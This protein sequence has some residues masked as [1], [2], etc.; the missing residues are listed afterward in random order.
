MSRLTERAVWR[1]LHD[2]AQALRSVRMLDL[3]AADPRR[4]E[5]FSVEASGLYLD[6][7]KQRADRRAVALLLQLAVEQSVEAWRARMF[8]GE[9]INATERRAALHVA[10]RAPCESSMQV[11]GVDVVPQVHAVL[12]RMSAFAERVRDGRWTGFN[13]G[14]ITDVVNL[15]IGGSDLGPRM[16][17]EALGSF[18]DG[19]RT[20]FIAN[21]DAAPLELLLRQ[22]DPATTLWIVASKSFTTLETLSNARLARAWFLQSASEVDVARHFVAVST[23]RAEVERFGIDPANMFEFWDWVGGRYSLWSAVGLPIIL[24][25]G[26]QR[27]RELL[28]GAWSMDRHF[29]QAPLAQNMPVLMAL[30]SIWNSNFVGRG[31]QVLAAY[32]QSLASFVNWAQQLDLESNGKSA[33]RDGERVDYATAPALWGD[34]GTNAQH[35]FFQMLHQGPTVHPVD[36]IVPVRPSHDQ[37]QQHRLLVANAL[38]QGWALMRG[39]PEVEVREE[40]RAAGLSGQ[41]LELAVPHR[42]FPGNRPSNTLLMPRLDAFHLGALLALYEHR[43]FVQSVV[44]NINAFDQWG[45]ELGKKLALRLLSDGGE[46]PDPS[47]A[48]LL[49]RTRLQS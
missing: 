3:F 18:A 41:E 28:D 43:T 47:T 8:A 35:A 15:G 44:W 27:F 4:V 34:V 17:C 48:E 30:L 10:L 24:G 2:H 7:A 25:L 49:R 14:R 26:P 39:K 32:T 1:Q 40:L 45:V 38:A 5:D 21:V 13:G 31:S 20:H 29:E 33:T 9:R 6:Y 19:P 36:F 42:V 16:V 37:P 46:D 12:D 23:N 22:L 11:D